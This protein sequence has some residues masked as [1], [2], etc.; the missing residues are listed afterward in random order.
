MASRRTTVRM[1]AAA[2]IAVAMFL[3][4]CAG[5]APPRKTTESAQAAGGTDA[6]GTSSAGPAA[7]P[8]EQSLAITQE[9]DLESLLQPLVQLNLL[10]E[11]ADYFGQFVWD[12]DWIFPDYLFK[13]FWLDSGP[14]REG[15]GTTLVSR[16]PQGEIDHRLSRALVEVLP[17]GSRWWQV[18]QEVGGQELFYEVLVSPLDIEEALRYLHPESGE[19]Y[20]YISIFGEQAEQALETMSE[21][22]L[23][24]RIQGD[25]AE[26]LARYRQF[27]VNDPQVLGQ[28]MVEVAAGRF[29]AVHLQDALGD[30]GQ[31]RAD[32]WLSPAVPGGILK[33]VYSNPGNGEEWTTELSE[34]TEGNTR[35]L[36]EVRA[37]GAGAAAPGRQAESE[38]SPD[39]PVELFVGQPHYGGVGPEDASYYALTVDR[40][41]DITIE[42]SEL[43]GDAELYY[44]A[45]DPT[46]ENW[47]T[48]SQGSSLNVEDYLVPAGTTL[49]FSVV[50]YSDEY[51]EGELYTITVGQSFVLDRT[52]IMMRGNIR[53]EARALES[54]RSYT[55]SLERD[56]LN[57]YEV[58]VRSGGTLMIEA[59]G[60]SEEAALSWFDA[61]GGTYSGASSS[62]E[63]GVQRLEI[64][65]LQPGTRCFFYISGDTG[66]IGPQERFRLTVSEQ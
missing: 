41:S 50:D 28:E 10:R 62:W 32:Y 20:E 38:G 19:H 11:S 61:E 49:Y 5:T 16:T 65:G 46:F 25:T 54:G 34:M 39:R 35:Q 14:Y 56:G 2:L 1:E 44:Y 48:S 36:L 22:E 30:E 43:A 7:Q 42:V 3:V 6:V 63:A 26:E 4:G 60:L 27:V 21:E 51:G 58:L 18:S 12:D 17:D 45:E 47:V 9:Y 66:S 29:P 64:D 40:Q 37:H 24:A 8:P 23:R 55:E 31:Y 33:M 15:Q 53:G 13:I 52:G 59:V 57:C